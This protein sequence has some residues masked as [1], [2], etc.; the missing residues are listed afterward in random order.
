[1]ASFNESYTVHLLRATT[2]PLVLTVLG[3]LLPKD[4]TSLVPGGLP[5]MPGIP[6]VPG[7]P[8]LPGLPTH[9]PVLPTH[10]PFAP[11]HTPFA[12]THKP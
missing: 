11:T 8:G 4:I 6:G 9:T 2:V 12:P 1:M 5:G 7:L 3:P 10:T